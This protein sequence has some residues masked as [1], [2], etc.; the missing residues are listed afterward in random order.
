MFCSLIMDDLVWSKGPCRTEYSRQDTEFTSSGHVL[1]NVMR[2]SQ[3]HGTPLWI[4]M[5]SGAGANDLVWV[6]E[7]LS[8]LYRPTVLIT[9]DGDRPVPSSF[10]LEL[11]EAILACPYIRAWRTQNYD[12]STTHPKLS[13]MPIGLDLHTQGRL[14]AGN[15]HDTV[16]YMLS[17]RNASVAMGKDPRIFCDAHLSIT[18][19]ER[20]HLRALLVANKSDSIHVQHARISFP[21]ITKQYNRFAFVLSPRGNGLD[22]HRTWELFIAGAIVITTTSSLDAMFRDHQLPVVI[23]DSWDDLF[24][25]L[26]KKLAQWKRQYE[27][28]TNINHVLPRLRFPHWLPAP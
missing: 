18:H 16:R 6:A 15:R 23:L 25:G 26:P 4:R 13:S 3:H 22:C 19:P 7:H 24:V 11:T 8:L 12:G 2:H 17:M 20:A 27:R 28:L 9:S 14:I 10:S 21:A 1:M 5:G